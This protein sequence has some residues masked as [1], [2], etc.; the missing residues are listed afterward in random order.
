MEDILRE[1]NRG[2]EK[3]LK[4]MAKKIW[5]IERAFKNEKVI[6]LKRIINMKTRGNVCR[7]RDLEEYNDKGKNGSEGKKRKGLKQTTDTC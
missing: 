1:R 5:K 4:V 6:I 2:V 7:V 3:T